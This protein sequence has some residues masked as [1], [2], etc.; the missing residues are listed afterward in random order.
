M[1]NIKEY[2]FEFEGKRADQLMEF[3]INTQEGKFT[4]GK[5][6]FSDIT[7]KRFI[8]EE[9]DITSEIEETEN[10]IL[11]FGISN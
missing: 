10:N 6:E 4:E 8:I 9:E 2:N 7:Y 11:L 1:E 3:I 5:P